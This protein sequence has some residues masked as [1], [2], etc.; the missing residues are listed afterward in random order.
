MIYDLFI[1][2]F[3]KHSKQYIQQIM[4]KQVSVLQYIFLPSLVMILLSACLEVAQDRSDLE[5]KV[6]YAQINSFRFSV[7]EGLASIR[8]LKFEGKSLH[9]EL[10][11]Q[12]PNIDI[13]INYEPKQQD[14]APVKLKLCNIMTDS[15]VL[16]THHSEQKDLFGEYFS[17]TVFESIFTIESGTSQIRVFTTARDNKTWKFGLFADVQERLNGVA[18]L[19]IP[20]KRRY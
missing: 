19:F 6:G 13:T 7:K 5:E 20:R 3:S 1:H 11:A 15:Q 2:M 16:L 9:V 8:T 4:R 14:T 10:W 12:A 18:D 17:P